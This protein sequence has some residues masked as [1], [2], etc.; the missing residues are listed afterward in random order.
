M[1]VPPPLSFLLTF[2]NSIM[3]EYHPVVQELVI[4]LL[5][6]VSCTL[7]WL[8]CYTVV[9]CGAALGRRPYWLPECATIAVCLMSWGWRCRYRPTQRL[10]N[11]ISIPVLYAW[12]Y[13]TYVFYSVHGIPTYACGIESYTKPSYSSMLAYRYTRN[14]YVTLCHLL[15]QLCLYHL[16][17]LYENAFT[18]QHDPRVRL[19]Y[20]GTVCVLLSALTLSTPLSDWDS[21][22]ITD[23]IHSLWVHL[24]YYIV[25]MFRIQHARDRYRARNLPVLTYSRIGLLGVILAVQLWRMYGPGCYVYCVDTVVNGI[26]VKYDMHMDHSRTHLFVYSHIK[27]N[28]HKEH[29]AKDMCIDNEEAEWPDMPIY[30]RHTYV[31]SPHLAKLLHLKRDILFY[32]TC[33]WMDIAWDRLSRL[34]LYEYIMYAGG[35]YTLLSHLSPIVLTWVLHMRAGQNRNNNNN[36]NGIIVGVL[37]RLG[38]HLLYR[39]MAWVFLYGSPE[40]YWGWHQACMLGIPAVCCV[41]MYD[42]SANMLERLLLWIPALFVCVIMQYANGVVHHTPYLHGVLLC[43]ATDIYVV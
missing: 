30:L 43:I 18:V 5:T 35:G 20:S 42:I 28:V 6:C 24:V 40:L 7:V 2:V 15:L 21:A 13:Y 29:I 22:W 38:C 14:M 16:G 33:H 23:T 9:V 32:F 11:Y 26:L 31:P 25:Y 10:L 4:R 17:I 37:W 36:N 3:V 1:D 41:Y 19:L 12:S 8:C 39:S 34:G 27:N